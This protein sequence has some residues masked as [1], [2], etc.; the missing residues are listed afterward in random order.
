MSRR[1]ARRAAGLR[2]GI[3]GSSLLAAADVRAL[4][5]DYRAA[6][7]AGPHVVILRVW[8]GDPPRELVERQLAEYRHASARLLPSPSTNGLI[9]G[10]DPV[11]IAERVTAVLETACGDALNVRVHVAGLDPAQ[12]RE[13]IAAVASDVVPLVRARWHGSRSSGR[14]EA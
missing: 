5:D 14:S 7:G 12:A 4:A 13:Q 11:E 10:T 2:L 9:G 1:A 8:L 6:G 3:I